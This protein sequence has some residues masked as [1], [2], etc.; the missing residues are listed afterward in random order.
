MADETTPVT[1]VETTTTADTVS[2]TI[3]AVG[4]VGTALVNVFFPG[5]LALAAALNIF[6]QVFPK[7]YPEL[8]K[9]IE[10][11]P[12]TPEQLAAYEDAKNRLLNPAEYYPPPASPNPTP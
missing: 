10:G 8:V 12:L 2:T 7:L 1:P 9:L 11:T 5:S 6:N 3:E 4:T